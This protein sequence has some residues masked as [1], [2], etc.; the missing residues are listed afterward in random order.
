M[1]GRP[2]GNDG[3]YGWIDDY[4]RHAWQEFTPWRPGDKATTDER[5]SE[6]AGSWWTENPARSDHDQQAATH[7]F[8]EGERVRS[9][10]SVGGVLGGAVPAGTEG[11]VVS[12]EHGLF[13][14]RVTVE[15]ANGYREVVS[16]D[17]IRYESGWF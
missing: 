16:P 12:I 11:H 4:D 9:T 17:A 1:S 15:F 3:G 13:E 6:S 10:R 5:P 14:Q 8:Q 2:E 7:R